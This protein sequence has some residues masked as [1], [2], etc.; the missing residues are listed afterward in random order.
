[1]SGISNYTLNQKINA[2]LG[3]TSGLPSVIDL[4]STLTAGNNAGTNDIDM[5]NN[6]IL[7]VNN[8][9]LTTI[10]GGAYPPTI[11]TPNLDAVLTTGNSAGTNDIDM[12]NN[13]ILQV[14]NI[15]LT[16]INGGAYPPLVADNTL[17]E[18]LT[19]GNNA[20]G[21]SIT[22]L[23]DLGVTTINGTAFPPPAPTSYNPI[24]Q[25]VGGNLNSGNYSVRVGYYI[26]L[27]KLVWFEVRITIQGK[28]GLGGGSEDIRIT[29]PITASSITDLT[30]SLNIGNI[31]SMNTSIVSAFAN[32]PSGGQDF[33]QFPIKTTASTGTSNAKVSD[34][35][36]SFQIRFGG[37]Y[38][39]D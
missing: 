21:L 29:L 31:V 25:S 15:D 34:I 28:G 16:T 35:G 13:D 20:G 6:D 36:S 9:D 11:T 2:I 18:V 27:G 24:L 10:N 23:N 30:Q 32:I 3:K 5:N 19:A 37:F 26:Q 33:V 39:T 8:I 17:T 14:N 7:Q 4:D 12:N 22:N 38:F 1:M